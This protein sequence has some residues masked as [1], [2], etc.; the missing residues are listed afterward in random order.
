MAYFW[1]LQQIS[2]DIMAETLFLHLVLQLSEG[3][4]RGPRVVFVHVPEYQTG[5]ELGGS[6]QD[7]GVSKNRGTPKWMV[8]NGKPS[9]T[10]SKFMI[11][12]HHYFWKH[13]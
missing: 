4:V 1:D 7:M 8:Y 3:N 2:G 10:L 11:W 9:K 6:E 5:N 13:P 12:G